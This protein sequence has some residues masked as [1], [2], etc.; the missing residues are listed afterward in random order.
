MQSELMKSQQLCQRTDRPHP[1]FFSHLLCKKK[2]SS[3]LILSNWQQNVTLLSQK[4]ILK[5][6]VSEKKKCEKTLEIKTA[7]PNA[8]V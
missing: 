7:S 6:Y 8:T 3:V 2:K 5:M 1:I 4:Y